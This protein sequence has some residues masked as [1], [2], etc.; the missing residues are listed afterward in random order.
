MALDVQNS[1]SFSIQQE[2]NTGKWDD[3]NLND[4]PSSGSVSSQKSEG[5]F[6]ERAIKTLSDGVSRIAQTLCGIVDGLIS[7]IKDLCSYTIKS[8]ST[9]DG[10]DDRTTS[11]M[12]EMNRVIAELDEKE[13]YADIIKLDKTD[14]QPE[15]SGT[16]I[17]LYFEAKFSEPIIKEIRPG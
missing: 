3:I 7:G 16:E 15:I 14:I 10:T 1:S 2:L 12:N 6:G 8:V 17:D 13:E 4:L 5:T 11:T 9:D